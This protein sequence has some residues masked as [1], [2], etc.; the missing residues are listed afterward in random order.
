MRSLFILV[1]FQFIILICYSQQKQESENLYSIETE[2]GDVYMGKIISQDDEKITILTESGKEIKIFSKY[3]TSIEVVTIT[4]IQNDGFY[5]DNPHSTKY[6]I[7]G[8]GY[9]L[10]NGEMYYQ[11]SM[12]L[13][14]QVGLG[15]TD[16]LSITAG[17]IPLYL[18]GEVHTP[19]W[20][21]PKLSF[22]L[23][24]DKLNIGLSG[25]GAV[26]LGEESYSLGILFGT[27]TIGKRDKNISI[28]LGYGSGGG[29]SMP[30]P[31]ITVSGM[32]R[33]GPSSFL[34]TENYY[35]GYAGQEAGVLSIGG[36]KLVNQISID[37]GGFIPFPLPDTF[38]IIP[39]FGIAVP[40]GEHIEGNID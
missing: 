17:T 25:L 22:P 37:F 5:F 10:K 13:F 28:G 20:F 3:I 30:G 33:T 40:F 6:F 11:N 27:A 23:I 32:L 4:G 7:A 31:T 34:I 38:F 18:L 14:N 15:L 19:I 26:M 39:W 29:E 9:G 2:N 1:L 12:I 35:M 8:T 21:S 36:R 24:E 16:N